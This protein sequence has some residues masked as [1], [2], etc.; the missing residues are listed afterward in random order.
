MFENFTESLEI[1][2][3]TFDNL[4]KILRLKK[5]SLEILTENLEIV[6]KIIDN[7]T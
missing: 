5:K 7:L 1:L 3:K 2:T 4:T 6:T